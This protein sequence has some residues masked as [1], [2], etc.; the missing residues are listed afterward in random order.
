MFIALLRN[1]TFW[2]L[3]LRENS[4]RQHLQLL[5]NQNG[6]PHKDAVRMVAH[7]ATSGEEVASTISLPSMVSPQG[8]H[9]N[10]EETPF[11]SED[12]LDNL[13]YPDEQVLQLLSM[14]CAKVMLTFAVPGTLVIT[15]SSIAFTADDSTSEYDSAQS[16][17][18][19]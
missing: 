1:V 18:S 19:N 5:G 11:P 17:V 7:N 6:S 15:K 9:L 14:Q 3:D 12:L 16:V 2:K 8:S 4:L 10:L 13:V